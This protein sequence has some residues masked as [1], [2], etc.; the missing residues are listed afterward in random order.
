MHFVCT[1]QLI[2]IFPVLQEKNLILQPLSTV[3]SF[4]INMSSPHVS[5]F[6]LNQKQLGGT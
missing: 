5:F 4:D 3:F 6:P 2:D 1:L